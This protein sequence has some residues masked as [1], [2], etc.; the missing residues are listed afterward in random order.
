MG[1]F[2]LIPKEIRPIAFQWP[3]TTWSLPRVPGDCT[4][5]RPQTEH[6]TP[7]VAQKRAN[8]KA[9]PARRPVRQAR[10]SK[11]GPPTPRKKNE[12]IRSPGNIIRS[13]G[14]IRQ[15]INKK[16]KPGGPSLD[17]QPP[18]TPL[19]SNSWLQLRKPPLLLKFAFKKTFQIL[20]NI[21]CLHVFLMLGSTVYCIY[22]ISPP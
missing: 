6:F 22:E 5:T 4:Q 14:N 8:S 17:R 18:G 7:R 19:I 20:L 3:E 10:R 15:T 11:P 9:V 1:R 21:V 13:P 12:K 2:L 16:H